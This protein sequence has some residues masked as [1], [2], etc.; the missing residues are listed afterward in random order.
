MGYEFYCWNFDG[1]AGAQ[2]PAVD[3]AGADS[4]AEEGRRGG[5][6]FGGGAA[7]A[8]FGAGSG[9]VLTKI[10][11]YATVIFFVLALVLGYLQDQLH[12]TA[13]VPRNLK[14]RCSR[15][16]C[17]RRA[18]AQQ[19]AMPT[20][21]PL[22][23]TGTNSLL[24]VPL[25][26][27]DTA[28]AAA[29]PIRPLRRRNQNNAM[30]I[31]KRASARSRKSEVRSRRARVCRWNAIFCVLISAFCLLASGCIRREPPADLTIIN[32]AE[33]ESLDPA[34]ITGQPELRIVIG[35]FEGLMRLDPKTARPIPG[36]AESWEISPDGSDLHVSSAHQSGLVHRRADHGGRR[37]VFLDSR[38][39]SGDGVG[40]RRAALLFEKRRGFQRRQNQ[41]PVARG[42][43]CA[44]QIHRARGIESS[45][46][47]FLD[48]CALPM[49][50]RGAAPDH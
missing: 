41:G 26:T 5:L 14:S 6:A 47:F 19:P 27:P 31:L 50:V 44:G 9:N 46:A 28:P 22:P 39:Q 43:S 4:I 10:T 18:A 1:V 29:P 49:T 21:A 38:A 23:A 2:L 42:R 12:T 32:G 37:G 7:D 25:T 16:R 35:L 34:I 13:T 3:F 40:L 30:A 33:P 11:K 48:I 17:K 8:L 20:A 24:S 45:H 36:L 15:N